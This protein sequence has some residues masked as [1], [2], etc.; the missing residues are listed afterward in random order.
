MRAAPL[1]LLSCL[2]LSCRSTAP[3]GE[4]RVAASAPVTT[5]ATG[6][7]AAPKAARLRVQRPIAAKPFPEGTSDEALCQSIHSS[8]KDPWRRF[9]HFLPLYLDGVVWVGDGGKAELE[10]ALAAIDRYAPRLYRGEGRACS[11]GGLLIYVRDLGEKPVQV[12]G[13][14]YSRAELEA[15]AFEQNP[16]IKAALREHFVATRE[17]NVPILLEHCAADAELCEELLGIQIFDEK[18]A[19]TGLCRYVLDEARSY[20]A[21]SDRF[22]AK[23]PAASLD[24]PALRDAC[25]R[26]PASDKVCAL[27]G[28][29]REERRGCWASLAPKL[30]L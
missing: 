6:A 28:G 24:E 4:Q 30:G 13:K 25:A 21:M 12:L 23:D 27:R 15:A 9:G 20:F 11:R 1:A 26:L 29:T 14:S 17:A 19:V 22:W 8:E 3:V 16:A 7:S 5:P 10:A 18:P 2:F